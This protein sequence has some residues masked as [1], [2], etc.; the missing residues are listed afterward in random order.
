M[1]DVRRRLHAWVIGFLRRSDDEAVR[2]D[3]I[4]SL[5]LLGGTLAALS[6]VLPHP[7]ETTLIVSWGVVVAATVVGAMLIARSARMKTL[8]LHA[9][10]AFGAVL[11]N[12]L[13]VASGVASGIYTAMFPWV[14]LVAVNFFSLRAA[15]LHYAWVMVGYAVALGVTES[16]SGFSPVTRWMAAAFGLAVTGGATAWLVDR[17]RVA[18][19]S[20]RR[21]LRLSE[22]MLCT[23]DGEDRFVQLNPAWGSRLGYSDA[24][25]CA[26]PFTALV[27]PADRPATDIALAKLRTGGE[28]VTV[29]NRCRRSDGTWQ[30]LIWRAFFLEDE[31]LVYARVRPLRPATEPDPDRSGLQEAVVG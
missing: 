2:G 19:E 7:E 13:I 15:F 4:G 25:L 28:A 20:Q 30:R 11:I 6:L 18:Q 5:F 29:E 12:A 23:I 8:Q 24:Q 3:V 26:Q 14:V 27:H 31:S 21:F 16:A 22:E 10:V 1:Y 9:A 17:R